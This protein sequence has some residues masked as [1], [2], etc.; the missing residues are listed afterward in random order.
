[1][2]ENFAALCDGRL[3]VVQVFE[4]YVSLALQADAGRILH[5]A[6]ARGPTSYTAFIATRDGVARHRAAFA[7]MT[8]AIGQMRRWLA[9][10]SAEDLASVTASFFPDVSRDVLASSLRHYRDARLWACTPEISRAG[11]ARLADSLLSGGFIAKLP[12]YGDCVEQSFA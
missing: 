4:P 9:E 8:R 3:D 11:F 5:A 10:N 12:V 7:A 6:N 2:A 1:M